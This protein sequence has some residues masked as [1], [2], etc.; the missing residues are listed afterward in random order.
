MAATSDADDETDLKP[1]YWTRELLS[2]SV[3]LTPVLLVSL[4]VTTTW[5]GCAYPEATTA[6]V[7]TIP[8]S[9]KLSFPL[10]QAASSRTE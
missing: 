7:N 9:S 2:S 1:E 10:A 4:K 6:V 5:K 8:L 3:A